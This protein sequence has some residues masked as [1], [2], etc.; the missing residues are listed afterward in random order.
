[1][2]SL[3]KQELQGTGAEQQASEQGSLQAVA[4]VQIKKNLFPRWRR[5]TEPAAK[6]SHQG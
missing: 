6:P 2:S 1:M 3:A 5:A 4:L